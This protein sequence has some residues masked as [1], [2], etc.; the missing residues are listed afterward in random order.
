MSRDLDIL[1]LKS[2]TYISPVI[3]LVSLNDILEPDADVPL[4]CLAKCDVVEAKLCKV[5]DFV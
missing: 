5:E 4:S 1:H 2:L 3:E